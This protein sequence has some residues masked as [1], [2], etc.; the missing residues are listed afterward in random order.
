MSATDVFLSAFKG[1]PGV[2]LIGTP[3]GG[4]SGRKRGYT[5]A[6]SGIEVRLSSMASFR[7]DGWLYDGS[8]IEPDV[9]APATPDDLIGRTDSVLDLAVS[10]LRP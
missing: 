4:G 5:L 8:G 7:A 6:H 1:R 2:T 9:L 3:S 10:R